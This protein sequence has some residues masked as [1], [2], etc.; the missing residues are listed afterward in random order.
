MKI[1]LI[2][3]QLL[4]KAGSERVF[5]Y[6]AKT[7]PEADLYTLCYNKDT[8][9]PEFKGLKINVHWLNFFIRNHGTFKIFFP[10]SCFAMKLWNFKKY[11]LIITSSATT[12][13]YITRFNA[14]HICYCYFPTRAIWSYEN[15][16][17]NGIG[18]KERFFSY[19]LNFF[20]KADISA[21]KNVSHFIAISEVTKKA[22]YNFYNRSSEI[23]FAPIEISHI[24][25]P[26]EYK[27]KDYYLVVSR[28]EKWKL[29][30]Y[31]IEAFNELNLP[32]KIVGT[33]PEKDIL[34][35]KSNQNIEFLGSVTDDELNLL[36]KEAKAVVFTPELEYGLVPLE[37]CSHGTPVIALGKGGVLE[38]MIGCD[39]E[40][41][42]KSTAV[43]FKNPN[44]DD[45][46]DAINKFQNLNFSTDF[47]IQHSKLFG[48]EQFQIGLKKIVSTYLQS[49]T[50]KATLTKE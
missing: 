34:E 31:S 29:V 36:Y 17:G 24:E 14:P 45:L 15:Y 33:G 18:L 22:I 27:K 10:I 35:S 32:L 39:D 11:D 30:D 42:Q 40:E 2:Q 41:I 28:L 9:W 1:A 3:D 5:L 16:F 43:L 38:T 44:K 7:Y 19:S 13:K 21:S 49:L 37:A 25:L 23:L 47:L 46:I 20:K 12:A 6:M 8:T 4:T 48:V 50:K 26:K